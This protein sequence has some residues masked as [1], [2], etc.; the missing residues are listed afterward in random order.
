MLKLLFLPNDITNLINI[1][2]NKDAWLDEST[3]TKDDWQ[4]LISALK[5]LG[6]T[7][8]V[9]KNFRKYNVPDYLISYLY[10]YILA[11]ESKPE[12]SIY[13]DLFTL[14]YE[15]VAKHEDKIIRD[16]FE[17]D[18]DL[19]NII[20]ALSLKKHNLPFREHLIGSNDLTERLNKSVSGDFGLGKDYP[21]FDI[22]A[23]LS[24]QNDIIEK[25]KGLDALRWKWIENEIFFEYFTLPR[26]MG[27][28]IKLHIIYRW[29]HLSQAVGEKRFKQVL[30]DLETSF[31][32]PDEFA[33]RKR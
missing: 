22:L 3:I 14:F 33:L 18:R 11:D 27:Y 24:E 8:P 25:E 15:S 31:E 12:Q 19:K 29:I 28:L 9:L 7:K 5:E 16:W 6:D 26:L 2:L 13:K 23:R 4:D 32:F 30:H 21:Y 10:D 1:L 17:F 20:I